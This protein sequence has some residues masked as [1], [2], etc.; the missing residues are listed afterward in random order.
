M[1]KTR[2]SSFSRTGMV[3]A[4]IDSG[5][6]I[7][8]SPRKAQILRSDGGTM[9]RCS[10]YLWK[11]AWKIACIGPRPIDTVGNCQKSGISQGCGYEDSPSPATS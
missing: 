8:P 6:S 9:P 11:R 5:S 2:L 4:P 10:R 3:S 1:T 7:S